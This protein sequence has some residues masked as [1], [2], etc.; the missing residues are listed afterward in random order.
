MLIRQLRSQWLE[1]N[2]EGGGLSSNLDVKRTQWRAFHDRLLA[3]GAPPTPLASQFLLAEP[4]A[5]NN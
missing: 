2:E 4:V 3:L 5:Q 1:A